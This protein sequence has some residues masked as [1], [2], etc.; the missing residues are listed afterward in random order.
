MSIATKRVMNNQILTSLVA[1]DIFSFILKTC[2]F[3]SR[4]S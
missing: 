4:L 2:F 1:V 3:L